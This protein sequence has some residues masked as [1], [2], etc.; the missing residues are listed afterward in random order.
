MTA[1]IGVVV[2]DWAGARDTYNLATAGLVS[3]YSFVEITFALLSFRLGTK[4]PDS[5]I[6]I[7]IACS[8][9]LYLMSISF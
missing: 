6:T 2:F 9:S 8:T 4:T 5:I 1:I 7:M 3:R